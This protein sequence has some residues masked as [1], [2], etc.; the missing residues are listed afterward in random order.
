VI[1]TVVQT[2]IW[3]VAAAVEVLISLTVLWLIV[4]AL[5][6]VGSKK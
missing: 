4:R 1:A 6:R 3:E 5:W 2:L